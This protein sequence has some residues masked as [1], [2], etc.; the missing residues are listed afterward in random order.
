MD[1][2]LILSAVNEDLSDMTLVDNKPDFPLVARLHGW[3]PVPA[4]R[5]TRA[6]ERKKSGCPL[7]DA[8]PKAHSVVWHA[9]GVDKDVDG[10]HAAAL[11]Q[12]LEIE[13]AQVKRHFIS[14]SF[15]QPAPLKRISSDEMLYLANGLKDREKQILL[16]VYRMRVLKTSQ[17]ADLF[18]AST[19]NND[20]AASKSALRTL[21][22]L[23]YSHMLY[24]YSTE[25]R[26]SPEK[27]YFLGRHAAPFIERQE[28]RLVGQPYVT[29]AS[30]VS[31]FFIEHDVNAA[32]VFVQMRKQLYA[33]R[34]RENLVEVH[35]QKQHLHLPAETWWSARS[36][37]FAYQNPFT[38]TEQRIIPDGFAALTINDGRHQQYRL[39]FFY[40]WD[41]GWKPLEETVEQLANYVSFAVSG[42]VGK[43]FPKL[44]VDGYFPPVLVVTNT[45]NRA[46]KLAQMTREAC[47]HHAPEH[48]PAMF[49][50]DME[51]L[52]NGAWTPGAWR[53]VHDEESLAPISLAEHL[54]DANRVLLER[55]PIH[56]RMGIE[57]DPEG[58]RPKAK[59]APALSAKRPTA[60]TPSPLDIPMTSPAP[61]TTADLE[62]EDEQLRAAG[63]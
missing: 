12:G 4:A 6:A 7:C 35:G 13:L 30:T 59:G 24:Q 15:L 26:K 46:Y 27:Y 8:D 21:H 63:F 56:W 14:H 55:A 25:Q 47:A 19:T 22:K 28:G 51:T 16:A 62:E 52:R 23:R 39:P 5:I 20:T 41:S 49:V 18:F 36:L 53:S 17:I 50:T 54:L 44:E 48:V 3:K 34:D 1:F 10:A 45:P 60:V 33:N 11:D 40:E 38:A 32:E 57:M 2:S 43:R 9:Y 29:D 58:A 37:A 61:A 31:E 42:A